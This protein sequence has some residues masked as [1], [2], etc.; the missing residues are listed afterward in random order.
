MTNHISQSERN[1]IGM[2]LA[3][4]LKSQGILPTDVAPIMADIAG[5]ICGRLAVQKRVN[6][7]EGIDA[8]V[9]ILRSSAKRAFDD[10]RYSTGGRP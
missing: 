5:L 7:E 9:E 2:A 10:D 4:W 8:L 3:D 1:E 6:L